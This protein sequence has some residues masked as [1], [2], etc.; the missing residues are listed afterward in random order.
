MQFLSE[1]LLADPT[2]IINIV[3]ISSV[4]VIAF[5]LAN[6]VNDVVVYFLN[7]KERAQRKAILFSIKKI[8]KDILDGVEEIVEEGSKKPAKKRVIK[9]TNK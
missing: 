7:R 8:Q 2:M 3:Y 6:L 4:M 5:I 1:K 9:K